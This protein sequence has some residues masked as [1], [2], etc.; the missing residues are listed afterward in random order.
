[1]SEL[2][3]FET[4]ESGAGNQRFEVPDWAEGNYELVVTAGRESVRRPVTLARDWQLMLSSDKPVYQP[5]QTILLRALALRRPDL[6]PVASQPAVFT[7]ADPKGN[8]IFKQKKETSKFGITSAECPLA[9]ELIEGAYTV[10]CKVGNTESKL[11]LDVK[12]YVLPKF[13][14]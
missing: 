4:D 8:V 7:I 1:R 5:G 11:T 14:V 6:K 3:Q 13:K 2:A 12:R 10:T 9:G